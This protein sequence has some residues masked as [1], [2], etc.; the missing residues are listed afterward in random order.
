MDPRRNVWT[1]KSILIEGTTISKIATEKELIKAYDLS[2]CKVINCKHK[3]VLPGLINTH[4]HVAMSFF[5]GL[6][7]SQ[8]AHIYE[9]MFP[10]ERQLA[11]KDVYQLARLGILDM[12]R[13]GTTCFADHYYF[14]H[15]VA[16]AAKE[17]G[18]R[19]VLGQTLMDIQ[20]PHLGTQEFDRACAFAKEYAKDT[21]ITPCMGP[22][23]T[24]TVSP[25]YLKKI[26]KAAFDNNMLIHMHVAQTASEYQYI[27]KKYS[28][29][30]VR[31][32]LNAG[33]FKGKFMGAHCIYLNRDDVHIMA[34]EGAAISVTPSSEIVFEKL[35]PLK[36]MI[37][38]GVNL[39]L[40]TDC[41]VAAE[42]M[43]PLH[44]MK[45]MYYALLQQYGRHYPIKPIQILEMF[46][47]NAARAL[48]LEARI[49][50]IEENKLADLVILDARHP[51][52]IPA[53]DVVANTVL[54]A[55]DSMVEKVIVNGKVIFEDNH[56][57]AVD[58]TEVVLT[59]ENCCRRVSARAI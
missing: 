13:G 59:A 14:V 40:G 20:G 53:H 12:L 9:Q 34:R 54:C 52:F 26:I 57:V 33:A 7:H 55:H 58:E 6:G 24:E 11:G 2:K 18:M 3:L 56:P 4:T 43:S 38:S 36:T 28:C 21:L 50:S 17:F 48:G 47:I 23:A 44:E 51:S 25:A 19:G 37:A 15:D 42:S 16:R 46:T 49:G 45:K 8:N 10:V 30:P 27:R 32:L 39:V 22:H 29:S 5:R 31:Y 41:V 35:P 1:N